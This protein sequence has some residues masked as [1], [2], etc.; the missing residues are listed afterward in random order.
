MLKLTPLIDS[1]ID[2]DREDAVTARNLARRMVN[3]ARA[4]GQR[5]IEGGLDPDS[6]GEIV[7][8]SAV[9]TMATICPLYTRQRKLGLSMG[10]LV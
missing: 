1:L 8:R 2:R 6:A 9:I 4:E 7:A 3:M 10:A 5:L